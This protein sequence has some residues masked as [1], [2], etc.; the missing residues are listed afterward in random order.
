MAPAG[1]ADVATDLCE[2]YPIPIIC[3]LL[4]APKSGTVVQTAAPLRPDVV[5]Q[6][7]AATQH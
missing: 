4:G 6:L 5:K 1:R 7:T 3:E 2:P